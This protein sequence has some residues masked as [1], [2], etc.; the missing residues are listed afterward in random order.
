MK[1]LRTYVFFIALF[2]L[3]S[4]AMSAP[5]H[6]QAPAVQKAF[7]EVKTKLDDLI[8][9]KDD[10][11][12]DNLALRV[13]AFKKVVEFSIEEVKTLKVKLF[14]T[15]FK[16][17]DKE[18]FSA[19][20]DRMEKGLSDA[21]AYYETTHATL[22]TSTT[23][24]DLQSLKTRATEFKA[25]RNT[26]FVPLAYEIEGWL[27]VAGQKKA[28]EVAEA[29]LGKIASD[30]K[31]LERAKVKGVEKL[32]TL[33]GKAK[34]HFDDASTAYARAHELFILLIAP[35]A[36]PEETDEAATSLPT[37]E[38]GLPADKVGT[39]PVA[40]STEPAATDLPAGEASTDALP[41]KEVVTPPS[42]RDEI[43]ASLQ[44]VK[45][46][47]QTFIEMSVEVKKILK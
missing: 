20:R 40:T 44:A 4:T 41:E 38:A 39:E 11:F 31:K 33:F 32:A 24:L 21:T 42:I 5:A 15:D 34:V 8:S 14:A 7:E 46:A 13:Q 37:G 6:A 18:I 43:R 9:A 35:P 28:L 45:Q 26:S 30:V 25:W 47:Y 36:P 10:N 27:L 23:P 16:E 12:A 17:A 1:I 3:A 22:T 2:M 29:R 19:W